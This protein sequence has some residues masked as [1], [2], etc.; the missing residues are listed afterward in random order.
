MVGGGQLQE[1]NT[2]VL[3]YTA[4]VNLEEEI[5]IAYSLSD[6]SARVRYV[7]TYSGEYQLEI[8]RSSEWSVIGKWELVGCN[9]YGHCGPY[10]YCDNTEA[11][12]PTC[13]CLDGF[14]PWSSQDWNDGRF[15]H[16]CRRKEELRCT[17]GFSAL[18][19]MKP[20]DKFVLVENRTS[21]ECTAGCSRDC[22]CVAYAYASLITS[23]AT[24]DATRCLVWT[25]ELIDTEKFGEIPGSDAE[26][27]YLRGAG[28][29][30]SGAQTTL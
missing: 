29:K 30:D 17:D 15:F 23:R 4:I 21:E 26:T 16:G 19:G 27:L 24:G 18:P 28:F 3:F 12:G 14:E 1:N 9:R 5:Y 20:P 22:S 13:K 6:S 25:G 7:L 8:W 11:V 10:G 2:S